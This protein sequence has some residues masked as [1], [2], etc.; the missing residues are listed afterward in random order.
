MGNT[1]PVWPWKNHM[2]EPTQPPAYFPLC[3]LGTLIKSAPC[4]ISAMSLF[5][6]FLPFKFLFVFL[7]FHQVERSSC[8]SF[9]F[10]RTNMSVV[11]HVDAGLL[12][13][14]FH[15]NFNREI[16]CKSSQSSCLLRWQQSPALLGELE[17]TCPNIHL[18]FV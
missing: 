10:K 7:W 3:I 9:S 11:I 18:F 1:G 17:L 8:T 6:S 13:K 12:S 2:Q 14:Y 5:V 16:N 15:C 4:F